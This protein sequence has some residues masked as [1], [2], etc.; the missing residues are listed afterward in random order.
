MELLRLA[1]KNDMILVT[2]DKDFARLY[3]LDPGAIIVLIEVHPPFPDLVVDAF[4]EL[5]KK[6][7]LLQSGGLIVVGRKEIKKI[8]IAP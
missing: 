7:R 2:L 8:H 1:R 6:A 3:F 4:E 5:M